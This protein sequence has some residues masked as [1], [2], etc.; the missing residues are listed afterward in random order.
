MEYLKI[1]Q[2]QLEY[3][4][5]KLLHID[6]LNVQDGQRIG[7]IGNNGTGKTTLFKLISQ[8]PVVFRITGQINRNCQLAVASQIISCNKQSG[9]ERQHQEIMAAIEQISHSQKTLLLLDEPTSNLDIDQQQW[10]IETLKHLETPYIV[11]SH[12]RYFLTQ[13]V[14]TIWYLNNKKIIAYKESFLDFEQD[15]KRRRANEQIQYHN[16]IKYIKK[17]KKAQQQKQ[18]QVQHAD[19][20]KKNVSWSEWKNR[21]YGGKERRL[22]RTQK[23]IKQR[24]D[25]KTTS[26]ARPYIYKP[27]TLNNIKWQN[28]AVSMNDNL[29]RIEPQKITIAQRELFT[30]T[31]QLKLKV[32]QKIALTGANGCGKSVFLGQLVVQTLNEWLNPHAQIGFFRQNFSRETKNSTT[33][34]ES[35]Q[36]ISQFN[37]TTTMQLLG[38]LH[39]RQFLPNEIRTLSG[40]QLICYRLAQV[41]LGQHNL[42]ILDEPSN[43]LDLKSLKAVENFLKSYPFTV[44]IVTHDQ[45]LLA[46]LNFTTW[47]IQN[48]QLVLATSNLNKEAVSVSNELALLKFK[49]AQAII[50]PEISIMEIQRLKQQVEQLTKRGN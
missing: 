4:G 27:I 42:L 47:K 22:A 49:L 34:Q 6:N 16:Q 8:K 43:F 28:S 21:D 1:N 32:G 10:L 9:G 29:L 12:D 37:W 30:I 15:I 35:I 40:G 18:R 19:C 3:Q 46:N 50:D 39:L 25:Q 13:A 2:L 24:I 20:K 33:L 41:L 11:I 38:D 44:I 17:L 5:E 7:L 26:T 23:I 31:T 45:Q 48:Q 14:N 36:K